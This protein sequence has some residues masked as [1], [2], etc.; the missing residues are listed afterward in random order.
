MAASSPAQA[1]ID[2]VMHCTKHKA[3]HFTIL[4]LDI[5]TCEF[6]DIAKRYRKIVVLIHPDKCKLAHASDAFTVVEK[7]YRAIPDEG[8][9]NRLKIAF[10][11]KKEREEK[12]KQEAEKR[13]ASG[14]SSGT[15]GL[16]HHDG[17]T[18]EERLEKMKS[19][20]REDAYL[21][22]ARRAQEA[23]LKKA[24]H[25]K[26]QSDDSVIAAALQRQIDEEKDLH[27]F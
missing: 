10:E 1:E 3:D 21:E 7:A 16:V 2:R 14:A 19:A 9:L 17:L 25:E 18:K 20:A 23:A 24:R 22:A 15:S 13:K 5:A 12:L 8:I 6:T 11:R 26:K 4:G 27:L